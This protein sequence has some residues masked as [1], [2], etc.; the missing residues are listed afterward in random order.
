L[1][2]ETVTVDQGAP[3]YDGQAEEGYVQ[4]T[5]DQ[6][7]VIPTVSGM[8]TLTEVGLLDLSSLSSLSKIGVITSI[9]SVIVALAP[10]KATALYFLPSGTKYD[11]G[12]AVPK[13]TFKS[14]GAVTGSLGC[15]SFNGKLAYMGEGRFK[16]ANMITTR[17]ACND[18]IEGYFSDMLSAGFKMSEYNG[19]LR[20]KGQLGSLGVLFVFSK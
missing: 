7:P 19:K 20:L 13:I 8:P 9:P 16:I 4:G 3:S 17:M 14:T 2:D 18:P 11:I 15:N 10:W 6:A 5:I 12:A 1:G